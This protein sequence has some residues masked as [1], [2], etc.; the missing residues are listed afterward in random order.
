MFQ[1]LRRAQ[2]MPKPAKSTLAQTMPKR[3]KSARARTT[4]KRAKS[5]A[6][7]RQRYVF[8]LYVRNH[9]ANSSVAIANAR[10]IC[11]KLLRGKV[12]LEIIDVLEQPEQASRQMI[13]AVPTLVRVEP[14]P[15]V[16]VIGDLSDRQAVLGA[17]G[18][19]LR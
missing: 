8:H 5:T 17:L 1:G 9:S 12:S 7:A 18:L 4:P 2:T 11:D 19:A 13:I 16:K 6:R 3:A 15:V 10:D 14:T